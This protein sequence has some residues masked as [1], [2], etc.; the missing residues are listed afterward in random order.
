[1]G[2]R[3]QAPARRSPD[4][5]V[6]T[7]TAVGSGWHCQGVDVEINVPDFLPPAKG[8]AKS[9][10]A[11]GHSQ[12]ARVRRLLEASATA[13]SGA[14]LLKGNLSLDVEVFAPGSHRLPDATN[15]LGGIGDVLQAR[16]TGVDVAHLGPLAQVAVFHDDSQIQ[17]IRYSR[18][19]RPEVGYRVVVRQL[20]E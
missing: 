20:A 14:D 12:A 2:F 4:P 5:Q 18:R 11:D 16:S 9:M 17:Q 15:M 1:M 3:R 19:Y 6:A 10:L 7:R 13:L 8:E